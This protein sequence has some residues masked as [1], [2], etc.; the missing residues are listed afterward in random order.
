LQESG[1]VN[2]PWQDVFNAPVQVGGFYVVTLPASHSFRLFRTRSQVGGNPSPNVVAYVNM[3]IR[4]GRNLIANPLNGLDNHLN[5][6]IMLPQEGD[7]SS[8]C[9]AGM[10]PS[11]CVHT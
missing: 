5:T 8:I 10:D 11:N 7:G 2:G 9:R 6:L 3:L 1:N 4:P